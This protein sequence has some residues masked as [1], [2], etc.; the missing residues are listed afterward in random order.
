MVTTTDEKAHKKPDL[1]AQV[2]QKVT[3]RDQKGLKKAINNLKASAGPKG[4]KS[5]D[6]T[7][8]GY[9]QEIASLLAKW[10]VDSG[11]HPDESTP[12]IIRA[13]TSWMEARHH[14]VWIHVLPQIFEMLDQETTLQDDPEYNRM[15]KNITLKAAGQSKV[16]LV[17][18]WTRRLS[19]SGGRVSSLTFSG[20][21]NAWILKGKVLD[22]KRQWEKFAKKFV[23]PSRILTDNRSLA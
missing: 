3:D 10:I 14:L 5:E 8:V 21:I 6:T 13:F 23:E 1:Q 2:R 18:R 12:H 19:E 16:K 7:D 4:K 11:K 20:W 22:E 15:V 17:E 9:Q